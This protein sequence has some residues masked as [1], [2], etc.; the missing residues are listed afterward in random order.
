MDVVLLLGRIL[1]VAFFVNSSIGAFAYRQMIVGYARSKGVPAPEILAP[2]WHLWLLA[3]SVMVLLGLWP[4]VAALLFVIFLV[5]V[6]WYIHPFWKVEPQQRQA[7]LMNF[8][9]NLTFGGAALILFYFFAQG[10]MP[11]SLTGPLLRP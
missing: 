6:T 11:Y 10:P 8:L 1:F 9:R 5:P 3:G 7:E 4:D 2:G